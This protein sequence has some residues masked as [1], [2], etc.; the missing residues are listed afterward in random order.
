MLIAYAIIG[1]SASRTLRLNAKRLTELSEE[2]A[3]LSSQRETL[4]ETYDFI[5]TDEYV[6]R[7]ARSDLGMLMHDEVRYVSN[8]D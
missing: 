7:T 3:S 5:Q 2:R 4:M 8:N 1:L 6:I